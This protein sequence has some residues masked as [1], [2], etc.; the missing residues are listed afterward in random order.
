V[1]KQFGVKHPRGVVVREGYGIVLIQP[2]IVPL[3][4]V[5][6]VIA[7]RVPA[8]VQRVGNGSA[9]IFELG[10]ILHVIGFPHLAQGRLVGALLDSRSSNAVPM[11]YPSSNEFNPCSPLIL[12]TAAPEARFPRGRMARRCSA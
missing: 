4:V 9:M 8:R 11:S 1:G 7:V 10:E 3:L 12:N 5:E 6:E 2:Q